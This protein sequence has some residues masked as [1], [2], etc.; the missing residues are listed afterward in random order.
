VK[1]LSIVLLASV[2]FLTIGPVKADI[3]PVVE[4]LSISTENDTRPFTLGYE[5]SLSTTLDVTALGYWAPGIGSGQQVGI[6]DTSG[7]LLAF[8]P[9]SNTDPTVGHF[10]YQTIPGLVLGPGNYV[11]GGTYEGGPL[12]AGAVGVTSQPGYTWVTDEQVFGSGLN[13]PN[14]STSGGYGQN[15]IFEADFATPEPSELLPAA[16][17]GMGIC[18]ALVLRRRVR[19]VC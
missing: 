5:F 7:D 14:V 16:I 9:V 19:S 11:I 3:T 8:A 1:R 10:V 2:P 4:Y 17:I 13:F 6:W 18:L 15:G 12:P